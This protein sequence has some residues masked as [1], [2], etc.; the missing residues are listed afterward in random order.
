MGNMAGHLT[1]PTIRL[2]GIALFTAVLP[3]LVSCGSDDPDPT[4]PGPTL[5]F[6][7]T[8]NPATNFGGPFGHDRHP[9]RSDNFLVFGASASQAARQHT[10]RVAE[11]SLAEVL[12]L[13][14]ITTGDFDFLPSYAESRIHV[15][16][17]GTEPFGNNTGFAYRD[18]MVVIS[19]EAP[20]Y[21]RFGFEPSRY[22]RLLKHETTHVVEFLLIGDPRYPQA[23]DV[24]WREGF[25]HY[26]SRPRPSMITTR[27]Q[28]ESW[29]VAHAALPGEG[30]PV[31][32]HVWNDF[33][34]SVR[35]GGQTFSYY[36]MF[37][38]TVRY[39]LDPDGHGGTPEQVVALYDELGAGTSFA[40]AM[41]EVF[42]LELNAFEE[43]YWG[44]ILPYLDT[45]E[46]SESG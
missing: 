10:S 31:A 18:G 32:V 2:L 6:S 35:T 20:Q 33:P 9:F 8:W 11:E 5:D 44:I 3:P 38:L 28:V 13:L 7:G 42:G 41:S 19:T 1:S 4:E 46:V 22:K 45:V 17:I 30:N 26:T 15:M 34:E 12:D 25:A 14:S 39:L 24:W 40:A 16:A 29:M 23:S 27:A 21:S 36:D 43:D 37:E